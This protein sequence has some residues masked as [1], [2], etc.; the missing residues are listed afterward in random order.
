MS[1]PSPITSTTLPNG[2][3]N[4]TSFFTLI[5]SVINQII[6]WATGVIGTPAFT[7]LPMG[8]GWTAYGSGYATPSYYKDSMGYVTVHGLAQNT[9]GSSK[10]PG[11]TIATL[12]AGFRPLS[13]ISFSSPSSAVLG[14]RVDVL[15]TGVIITA[16]STI[17]N[18][19]FV[20]LDCIRFYAGV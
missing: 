3:V 7:N 20:F 11:T 1:L 5:W 18:S 12:P 19:G 17:A 16:N 2:F 8:S 14:D 13:Q 4:S 10:A 6:T 15:S 9:S